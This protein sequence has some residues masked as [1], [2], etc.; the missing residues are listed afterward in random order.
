MKFKTSDLIVRI[1]NLLR[2]LEGK[3][4]TRSEEYEEKLVGSTHAWLEDYENGFKQLAHNINKR[5]SMGQPV[6]AD[7]IPASIKAGYHQLKFYSA[8]SAGTPA[9][10]NRQIDNLL[11]LKSALQASTEEAISPTAIKQ[12]GFQDVTSLFTPEAAA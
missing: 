5:R 3:A 2:D 12:L 9:S 4:I 1:D 8:P 10:E 11:K 6:T 7:D